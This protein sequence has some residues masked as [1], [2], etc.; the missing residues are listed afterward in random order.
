MAPPKSCL[1]ENEENTMHSLPA[2]ESKANRR[3]SFYEVAKVR[4]VSYHTRR[5]SASMA[6]LK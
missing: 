5:S 6:A 2:D 3:V 4:K 1:K